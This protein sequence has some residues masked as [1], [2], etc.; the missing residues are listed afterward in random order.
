MSVNHLSLFKPNEHKE[1]H[2]IRSPNDENCLFQTEDKK[3]IYVGEKLVI[4]ETNDKIKK[5]STDIRFNDIEFPFAYGEKNIYFKLLEK[6]VPV[7]EQKNFN[8]KK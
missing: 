6:Y 4:F 2:H 8:R 3:F 7:Q 1:E 5:F